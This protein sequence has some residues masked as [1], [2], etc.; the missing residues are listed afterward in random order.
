MSRPYVLITNPLAGLV[1]LISISLLLLSFMPAASLA[2]V[3][4][5]YDHMYQVMDRFHN[6]FDVYTNQDEGG[7][8]FHPS[9]FMGDSSAIAINTNFTSNCHAGTSCIQITFTGREDNWAG[10]YWQEP[11]NNWGTVPNAGYNL[12]GATQLTF[13]A[14]G[15]NGG[16]RVEFFI[17]GITGPYSDSLLKTSTGYLTLSTS[18]QM[19]TIDLASKDL[20]NVIGGFGW[21]TNSSNNP[22]GATFYLDDIRYNKS[23]PDDLRFLASYETLAFIT[24]DTVI[25]NTCYVYDNSLALLSFLARGNDE[26]LR[27]AKILA[28]SFVYAAH[29]DRYYTDGRLR[30][31]YMSG[32]LSDHLTGKVRLP[33]WSD[34]LDAQWREDTG[35]VSSYTGNLA[36][37][38]I[39]LLSYYNKMGGSQYL[40]AAQM[41][42]EWIEE[43]TKDTRNDGCPG[44]YTGGYEGSEPNPGKITWKSTEHNIDVYVAFMLLYELTS[45]SKWK[46]GAIHA[47]NFVD[48]MWD[49]TDQHFWTGTKNDGCT[50]DTGNIPV[51]I[52]AWPLLALGSYN[53][54]LIGAEK[55]CY[56]EADGFKG[57]DF[58]NDL[59][60]IWFEGTGQMALAYEINREVSK[61][62]SYLAELTKAQVSATNANGKGIVAASHDGVTTGFGWQYFSRLHVGT[63]AWYIFAELGYNPFWGIGIPVPDIKANGLDGPMKLLPGDTLDVTVTLKNNGTSD[64]ADWWLAVNTPSGLYFY[65]V[66]GWTASLQPAYQGSLFLLP[67]FPVLNMPASALP[68]GTYT[69]FFGVDSVMDGNIT[70]G[71]AYYDFVQVDINK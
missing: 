9:G 40:D 49:S 2:D 65:T 71:N 22:S 18:W 45:D 34:P 7:N 59:D 29:N 37:A 43:K 19:Y 55:C 51:D 50:I 41:I 67:S 70:M 60:G 27:R 4:K 28:D 25:R 56:A 64:N 14:R 1:L 42:G 39:A 24:P 17:G 53:S 44:G 31:A 38:M 11:E 68:A 15:R 35:Q 36:W 30:N 66:A 69:V 63:T 32:D 16:E 47:K 48:A 62:N 23:R 57:F 61:S 21:I 10:I 12:T 20:S 46:D 52:Q 58:N 26:D 33:G 6:S 13:W 54:A 3:N 5:A 8:H